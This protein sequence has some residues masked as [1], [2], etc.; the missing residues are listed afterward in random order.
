MD[1]EQNIL[2]HILEADLIAKNYDDLKEQHIETV[3]HLIAALDERDA[4]WRKL[5]YL[6]QQ[7]KKMYTEENMHKIFYLGCSLQTDLKIG[8][9]KY[10]PKGELFKDY[11]QNINQSKQEKQ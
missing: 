10:K 5:H 11:M 2:R 7:V 6:K 8:N 4:Y 9:V 1:K 3:N